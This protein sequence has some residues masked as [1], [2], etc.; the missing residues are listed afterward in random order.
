MHGAI[1]FSLHKANFI[2]AVQKR[3]NYKTHHQ[4]IFKLTNN[5]AQVL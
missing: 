2:Y 5:T 3:K 4:L 1:T